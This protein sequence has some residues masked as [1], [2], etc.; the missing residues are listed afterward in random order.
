M[1]EFSTYEQV[2]GMN[3]HELTPQ[4]RA[5]M[6]RNPKSKIRGVKLDLLELAGNFERADAV[7]VGVSGKEGDWVKMLSIELIRKVVKLLK[8]DAKSLNEVL[9]GM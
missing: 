2:P 3:Y 5:R 4:Q 9:E 8:D 6:N 1:K 7:Q